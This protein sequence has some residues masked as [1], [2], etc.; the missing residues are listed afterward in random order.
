[1]QAPATHRSV[2]VVLRKARPDTR[3][4]SV[5]AVLSTPGIDLAGDIVHPSGLDFTA[6]SRTP[7]VDLE[8][9][10]QCVPSSCI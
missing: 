9:N 10:G 3:A 6:H 4:L 2:P 7:W 1:M 8:H 5:T